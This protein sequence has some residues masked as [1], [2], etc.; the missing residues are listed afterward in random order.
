MTSGMGPT[1][2]INLSLEEL[3]LVRGVRHIQ[4]YKK[5]LWNDTQ[6]SV[7]VAI[8]IIDEALSVLNASL[9]T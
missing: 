9:T 8:E 5:Q 6:S 1:V 7:H 2:I 3:L 4:N